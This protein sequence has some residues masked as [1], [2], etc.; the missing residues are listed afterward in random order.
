MMVGPSMLILSAHIFSVAASVPTCGQ[1]EQLLKNAS[2]VICTHHQLVA[3]SQVND[4]CRDGVKIKPK[5]RKGTCMK[6]LP[7][8]G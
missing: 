8:S 1:A 6:L 7:H 5:E 3:F 2:Q 4:F